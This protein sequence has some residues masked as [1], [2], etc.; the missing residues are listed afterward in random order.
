MYD[1]KT[2]EG[3]HSV[4]SSPESAD[5]P[6]RYAS[7]GGLTI[8]QYGRALAPANLSARQ[9]EALGLLTS[10]ICGP[11]SIILSASA[12]LQSSLASKLRLRLATGGS[13]LFRLTWKDRDTPSVR[14]ICAL[15]ASAPRT[16]DKD[17]GGWPTPIT[18]DAEKRETPV[19]GAGLAGAA[20]W[21][22]P[23]SQDG[24]NGGPAQGTDRFPGAAAT[25]AT[26][27]ARDWRSGSASEATMGR[28]SRPLNEQAGA[29]LNGSPAST[30]KRGQLNPAFS[31][32]LQG[33]P[34][35]WASCAPQAMPSSRR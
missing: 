9:A 8:N 6:T 33:F 25:W 10:G 14:R 16:S 1:Q 27:T 26:P 3:T 13:T 19:V 5:G 22:T 18:N 32:W 11:T 23:C 4:I 34:D 20:H 31:L 21:P 28:N 7:L 12:D 15:R 30:E 29:T 2:S 24:P 17:C 35:E